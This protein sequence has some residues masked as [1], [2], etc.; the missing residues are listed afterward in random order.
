MSLTRVCRGATGANQRSLVDITT[1]LG[2]GPQRNVRGPILKRRTM[3][4][5][6]FGMIIAVVRP[7]YNRQPGPYGERRRAKKPKVKEV[8]I[9]EPVVLFREELGQ[10]VEP[11]APDDS[12]E[13]SDD[14]L[15]LPHWSSHLNL[16]P[17]SPSSSD[18]LHEHWQLDEGDIFIKAVRTVNDLSHCVLF[19]VH[20]TMLA[21]HLEPFFYMFEDDTAPVPTEETR[22]GLPV[23]V[24]QQETAENWLLMLQLLYMPR[25]YGNTGVVIWRDVVALLELSHKYACARFREAAVAFLTSEWP[26]RLDNFVHRDS[27]IMSVPQRNIAARVLDIALRYDIPQV[28]P[29]VYMEL[30]RYPPPQLLGE[31]T[32]DDGERITIAA[33]EVGRIL[34]GR[35]QVLRMRRVYTLRYLNGFNAAARV[36]CESRHRCRG[37][38]CAEWMAR[39]ARDGEEHA[40]AFYDDPAKALQILDERCVSAMRDFVCEECRAR[41]KW[42]MTDGQKE[43]WLM[44][45]QAFGLGTWFDVER[46]AH[47]TVEALFVWAKEA[48]YSEEEIA[49]LAAGATARYASLLVG[50]EDF[51]LPVPPAQDEESESE[52]GTG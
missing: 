41:F 23:I 25:T 21:A 50:G 13:A 43:A 51:V 27:K 48:R 1:C 2:A 7:K 17:I 28:L 10:G 40:A 15:L 6:M 26:T 32:L 37:Y 11:V 39:L 46:R 24:T 5:M 35:E 9:D 29:A 45:P 36:Q 30:A 33:D 31:W 42:S 16:P 22:E 34:R 20:R 44:V 8:S 12:E 52:S 47:R 3:W 19:K 38:S 49:R 14:D 18:V 4:L